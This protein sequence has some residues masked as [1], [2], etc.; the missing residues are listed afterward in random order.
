MAALC[1]AYS[2][3]ILSRTVHTPPCL[4]PYFPGLLNAALG[5][6]SLLCTAEIVITMTSVIHG[7]TSSARAGL[8]SPLTFPHLVPPAALPKVEDILVLIFMVERKKTGLREVVTFT[9]C[10][11][12]NKEIFWDVHPRMT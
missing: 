3:I 7:P 6:H 12:T 10:H 2:L 8:G 9:C 1:F 4:P 11:T 5:H